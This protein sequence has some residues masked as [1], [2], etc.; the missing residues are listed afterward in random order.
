MYYAHSNNRSGRWHPLADHLNAVSRLAAEFSACFPWREEA[1][2]AGL[3]HD[4][5]KYGGRFQ[6]RLRGEDQGLDHWSQGAWL[7]LTEQ[8]AVAAPL[9][10]QRHHIGLPYLD[11]GGCR[12][13]NVEKCTQ[14]RPMRPSLSGNRPEELTAPFA[15]DGVTPQQSKKEALRL[16]ANPVRKSHA[17]ENS[18]PGSPGRFCLLHAVGDEGGTVATWDD[19]SRTV[20][21]VEVLEPPERYQA[22]KS[23]LAR[24]R[25]NCNVP[26]RRAT[27]VLAVAERRSKGATE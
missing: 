6:A 26:S 11:K 16:Q 1:R 24:R 15:A 25:R 4:L 3:L 2:L 8:K 22:V 23:R 27:P 12:Q 17:T 20:P 7:V 14:L 18:L 5:G 9:A 19:T 13:F 21:G 10:I